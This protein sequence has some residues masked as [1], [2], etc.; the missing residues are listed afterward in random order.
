MSPYHIPIHH[1]QSASYGAKAAKDPSLPIEYLNEEY[2]YA[3]I[4]RIKQCEPQHYKIV[5]NRHDIQLCQAFDHSL[6]QLSF[7]TFQDLA[8][9]AL[10]LLQRSY[11]HTTIQERFQAILV[12]EA[13]DLTQYSTS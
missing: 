1:K 8:P 7:C 9:K 5:P 11:A 3:L 2:A 6:K 13:Q 12:D 4:E 10:Q